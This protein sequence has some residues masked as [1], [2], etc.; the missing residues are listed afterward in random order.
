MKYLLQITALI[1]SL[2]FVTQCTDPEAESISINIQGTVL[3]IT[4]DD[5][6]ADAVV[7][8]FSPDSYKVDQTAAD[9]SF[10]FSLGVDSTVD[11]TLIF[12]KVGFISDT[13]TA[14][15]I[16]D[17]DV[18]ISPVYLTP[19]SASPGSILFSSISTPV[20]NIL[21]SGGIEN[22]NVTFQ[23]LDSLG[24]P[25]GADI[26]VNFALGSKPNGG[27]YLSTARAATDEN[28]QV[29]VG[30][31]A[32]T[33]GGIAEVIA[34]IGDN[35]SSAAVPISIFEAEGPGSILLHN[36]SA[37]AI[38]LF[39]TGGV[40]NTAITFQVLD[41]LGYPAGAG[42]LVDF[43]F[44]SH[45]NGGEYLS[46][47][48]AETNESG[49]A[50]V[51][52]VSGNMDGIVEVIASIGS[53]ISSEPIPITILGISE[54]ASILLSHITAPFITVIG[55]GG[56]DNATLT[57]QVLDSLGYAV[58]ADIMVNFALGSSPNGGEF[59]SP[60][61]AV[62]NN[63]GQ[64]KVNL[65][66]GTIAGVVQIIASIGSD[67]SSQMIPV[68]IHGGLPHADHFSVVPV[69]LN[70]PGY[71]HF[72]LINE[73][74]AFVG[75]KYGNFCTPGTAVY[76][77]T[78]GGLIEGSGLTEDG[79]CTVRLISAYPLPNHATLGPGY[80]TITARTANDQNQ[81]I[82]VTST[83]LFS[84]EPVISGLTPSTVN[85]SHLGTQSFSFTVADENG[86][87]LSKDTNISVV[88]E[89]GS[90]TA[91]GDVNKSLPDTQAKGLGTTNFG[92]TL[93]DVDSVSTTPKDVRVIIS[94]E[95]LNGTAIAVLEGSG[96]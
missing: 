11:L 14:L 75:D 15:A 21:G 47:A 94:T 66:S 51:N 50:S 85:V 70:F 96:S 58:G 80:A 42:V 65:V 79:A 19:T 67:V 16:P 1:I 57:F 26:L 36:V 82:E 78:D 5:P 31:V 91:V 32:G 76:F 24:Y 90:V 72:G 64:V 95:G 30:L 38:T 28:G 34:S 88:V 3:D 77:T 33:I 71:R 53:D 13:L 55:S 17:Q 22:A 27:E 44:G 63:D 83:V 86:N 60:D 68:S 84:G 93:I 40:E 25:V 41:S 48:S 2:I 89:E 18:T 56:V 10:L 8:L 37:P 20:I 92:F 12:S 81:A 35:I 39:G 74:T 59:F 29:S 46:T 4:N 9:G 49:Q 52:L 45:P 73:I 61:S 87:P 6:L 54:P 43:E 23:V 7:R 69:S 62:T